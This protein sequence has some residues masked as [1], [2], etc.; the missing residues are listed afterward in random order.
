MVNQ[1]VSHFSGKGPESWTLSGMFPVGRE[2]EKG[3]NRENPEKE[4]GKSQ[5]IGKGQGKKRQFQKFQIG[6][7][8]RLKTPRL[9][10]FDI[11]P[12]T[13]T[14]FICFRFLRCKDHNTA[15]EMNSPRDPSRQKLQYRKHLQIPCK[16]YGAQEKFQDNF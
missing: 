6:K 7:P 16:K 13:I 2:R 14:E 5:K 12:E 11:C 10:A 1:A 4:S 15:P 8:P 3:S 9:P